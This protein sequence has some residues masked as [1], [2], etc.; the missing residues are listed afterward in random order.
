LQEERRQL[1]RFQSAG[2][3]VFPA[4]VILPQVILDPLECPL[5]VHLQMPFCVFVF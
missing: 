1:G 5:T 4:L 3:G 2:D